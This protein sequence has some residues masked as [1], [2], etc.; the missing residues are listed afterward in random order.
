MQSEL[1]QNSKDS[2]HI[3]SQSILPLLGNN[4][5][6]FDGRLKII[7]GYAITPY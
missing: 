1:P 3:V 7:L 5:S 2:I 6:A 4:Q